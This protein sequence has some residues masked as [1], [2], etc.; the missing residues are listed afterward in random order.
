MTNSSKGSSLCFL[1]LFFLA[2][3]TWKFSGTKV[4]FELFFESLF[5]FRHEKMISNRDHQIIHFWGDRTMHMHGNSEGFPIN[6]VLYVVFGL[7]SYL[8]ILVNPQKHLRPF[9][10]SPSK[11]THDP[12]TSRVSTSCLVITS[13]FNSDKVVPGSQETR[14]FC[15]C[16]VMLNAE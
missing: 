15:G 3:L 4:F 11:P 14:V 8:M 16:F 9:F 6:S 1:E 5:F 12:L 13:R 10:S 7:V 2:F